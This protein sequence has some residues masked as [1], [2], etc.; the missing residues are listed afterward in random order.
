MTKW[1]DA[2]KGDFEGH[3][4]R[5]NQWTDGEGD[6]GLLFKPLPQWEDA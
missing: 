2:R 1:I 3:P 4:F 5:G 6:S